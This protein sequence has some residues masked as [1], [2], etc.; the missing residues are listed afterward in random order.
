MEITGHHYYYY[1]TEMSRC[2]CVCV[3]VRACVMVL[4]WSSRNEGTVSL[5][6]HFVA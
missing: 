3:C 2:V 5:Y 4:R 1:Y 6:Q